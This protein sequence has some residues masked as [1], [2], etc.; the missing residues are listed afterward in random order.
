MSNKELFLIKLGI[1]LVWDKVDW[2]EAA[3]S[4]YEPKIDT[5]LQ[6]GKDVVPRIHPS[7][8][9]RSCCDPLDIAAD[10]FSGYALEA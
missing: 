6:I 7:L 9:A 10:I 4:F 1:N 5:C 3:R 2:Y 8:S